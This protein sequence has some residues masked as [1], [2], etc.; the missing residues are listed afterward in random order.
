MKQ[1]E[2]KN[3]AKK[4]AQQEK[5]LQTSQDLKERAL[6]EQEIMK[7]CSQVKSMSDM[8]AVDDE[9]QSLLTL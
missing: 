7:L 2:I 4:I 3:L 6:A 1:K 5:I 8:I 9:V